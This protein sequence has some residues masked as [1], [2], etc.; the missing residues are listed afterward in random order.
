[1]VINIEITLNYFEFIEKHVTEISKYMSNRCNYTYNKNIRL[2]KYTFVLKDDNKKYMAY[3]DCENFCHCCDKYYIKN[4]EDH[5]CNITDDCSCM[6]YYETSKWHVSM[7]GF[8][9]YYVNHPEIN[10]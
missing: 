5:G 6:T 9:K 1:M 4:V 8:E 2:R 3:S 7:E 10:Y